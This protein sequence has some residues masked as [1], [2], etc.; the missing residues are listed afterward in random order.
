MGKAKYN[1][2]SHLKLISEVNETTMKDR[3]LELMDRPEA[4]FSRN[5][6][7][8]TAKSLDPHDVPLV[9]DEV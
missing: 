4:I 6:S 1:A 9:L 3:L 7:L 5:A 2:S 8:Q